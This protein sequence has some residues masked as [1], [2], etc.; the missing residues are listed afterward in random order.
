MDFAL[1]SPTAKSSHLYLP[2]RA[3]SKQLTLLVFVAQHLEQKWV[4]G[5]YLT[6]QVG[7]AVSGLETGGALRDWQYPIHG[8]TT[9]PFT[10]PLICPGQRDCA[11]GPTTSC[12]RRS[13]MSVYEALC[14]SL[15]LSALVAP[16]GCSG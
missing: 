3:N 15:F 13:L 10:Q 16:A 12:T 1:E 11:R 14:M 9:A 6:A 4:G 8:R 7:Y 2:R 5:L